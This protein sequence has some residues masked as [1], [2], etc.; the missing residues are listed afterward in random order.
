MTGK[1]TLEQ[2]L[3]T[4]FSEAG[5]VKKFSGNTIICHLPQQGET[6]PPFLQLLNFNRQAAILPF[7][8]KIACLPPSSYHVTI[9]D[10][11]NEGRRD[12]ERWPQGIA[13]DI[14][15]DNCNRLIAERLLAA[16]LPP[17]TNLR[18]VAAQD[19]G[20]ALGRTLRIPLVPATPQ[21]AEAL[22]VVRSAYAAATGI[23]L[24]KPDTYAFHIT[25]AY[26]VR[27]LDAS[28]EEAA[29]ALLTQLGDAVRHLA[30]PVTLGPPEYCTFADMFH[31][32]R[33][34]FLG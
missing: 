31:F 20:E 1:E 25:L 33:H 22:R 27:P 23:G 10:L 29:Q 9:F 15:I 19:S 11:C 12:G 21:D 24:E 5:A 17:V 7:A 32:Q 34:F 13:R 4:K 14:P 28:E 30:E 18:M 2:N 6:C 16:Q 8:S 26:V 3:N